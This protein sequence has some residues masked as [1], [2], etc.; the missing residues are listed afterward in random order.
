LVCSCNGSVILQP[1]YSFLVNSIIR[2]K[3]FHPGFWQI[4]P[5]SSEHWAAPPTSENIAH[6]SNE[7]I[8]DLRKQPIRM[9]LFH[10]IAGL[11]A[12]RY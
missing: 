7:E 2:K 9:L 5:G 10:S 6:V 1:P 12:T 4:A 3:L 11:F 8:D